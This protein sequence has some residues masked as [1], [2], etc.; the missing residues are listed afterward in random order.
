LHRG[1]L[2][3]NLERKLRRV[4]H[5]GDESHCL[6]NLSDMQRTRPA[7]RDRQRADQPHERTEV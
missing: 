1:E 2:A 6:L 5:P 4:F 7:A 3:K